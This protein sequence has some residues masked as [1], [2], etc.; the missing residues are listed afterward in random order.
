MRARNKDDSA[1]VSDN[2]KIPREPSWLGPVSPMRIAL[3]P[4][5]SVARWLLV[6]VVFAGIYFLHGFIVPVLAA[7]VVGFA[8]WPLYRDLLKRD[9]R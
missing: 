6:L 5:I 2:P 7:L 8:S 4:P 9:R 3:I 1:V